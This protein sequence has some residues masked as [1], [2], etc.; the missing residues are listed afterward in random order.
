MGIAI[1]ISAIN[2]GLVI[3]KFR[4]LLI[5]ATLLGLLVLKPVAAV[6]IPDTPAGEYLKNY[7]DA[8][9][10]GDSLVWR[11]FIQQDPQASDSASVFQ[12]RMNFFKSMYTD[13]GEITVEDISR[14]K[15]FT[16][17]CLVRASNTK[18]PYEWL[19][20]IIELNPQ[21]PHEMAGIE[22]RPADNP[23]NKEL[24]GQ[25]SEA[26]LPAY[27]DSFVT[28]LADKDEF[29][30]AVL[31]AKDGKPI[32]AK[33]YGMA[34]KRYDVFNRV[35]TKFNLGSMNK[36]FTGVA[37]G[38][39]AE[40]GKLSFDDPIIKYVPD[41]PNKEVA[42]KVTIH[43]LLTH[44]SGMDSYWEE[45][46]QADWPQIRTVQQLVDLFADK[47][48]LFEPGERFHYSNSGPVVLGLI[49]E[50]ITGM[51]YYDY[52]RENIYKPAGMENT[53]CYE[54]DRPVP[55][56]AMGYTRRGYTP[57]SEDTLWRNNLYMHTAKGGPAG[58]GYSTVIDLLKFDIAL[59]NHKLLSKKF[60]DIVTTGKV[61]RSAEVKYAFL[62]GDELV[63]GQRVIG[64]N[65][66]APGINGS[67]GIY[68]DSGYTVAV[69]ANYDYA[70]ETVARRLRSAI[71]SMK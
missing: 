66:G 56:L 63:N 22:I 38:Q 17:N 10:S 51:S 44:T 43:Q 30:G 65:G 27:V 45:L 64:H 29:S 68:L 1:A 11:D 9:N 62:F 53:D 39:L 14:S 2:K 54:L 50:R 55:N 69:L 37:I 26:S 19:N 8:F 61:E 6:N 52:I 48:L 23:A 59:R 35:D 41:Y 46:W 20:L 60:T 31:V 28:D 18:G 25:M 13:L 67:L 16:I 47:P 34:C 71:T 4:S 32:F 3:M 58:G 15:D 33:A 70:A 57:G 36:M 49:I 5:A 24:Y 12:R 42:E 21:P 40:Q 7:L